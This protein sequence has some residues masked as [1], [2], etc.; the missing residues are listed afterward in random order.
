M[1]KRILWS[2][3]ALFLFAC[4]GDD[5]FIDSKVDQYIKSQTSFALFDTLSVNLSTVLI[6]SIETSGTENMLVGK[7]SDTELGTVT[8][9]SYFELDLP[10]GTTLDENEVYDSLT[11]VLKYSD[12]VYGDTLQAQTLKVYRLLEELEPDDDG[13]IY[14]TS[15]FKYDDT[16]IGKITYIPRPFKSDSIVIRLDDSLGLEFFE[17]MRGKEDDITNDDDFKEYFKGLVL[18]SEEQNTAV[19]SFLPDSASFVLMHSHLPGLIRAEKQRKFSFSTTGTYFN[20]IDCD[21]S[22]TLLEQILTQRVALP[23][24]ETNSK[25]FIQ[26][27]AGI[28]M[29]VNLPGLQRLLEFDAGYLMYKAELVLRLYPNSEKEITPPDKL[30]MYYT[31]KYNNLVTEVLDSDSETIYS[32]HYSDDIYDE[33]NYYTFDLTQLLDD[34][35][36]DGYVDDGLGFI[37]TVPE[38]EFKGSLSRLVVD[39]RGGSQYRPVLNIYYA[40]FE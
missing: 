23:S 29:R 21:R 26:S 18:V 31:D 13:L 17:K 2:L 32:N 24:S 40:F 33:Y 3:F 28:V 6:D 39:A 11:L 20:H 30:L 38:S 10:S 16:P 35:L 36:S 12:L 5:E 4:T 15:S 9:S 8:A 27:G 34:E 25:A 19:L 7:Y 14:N 22:G 1:H 37:I